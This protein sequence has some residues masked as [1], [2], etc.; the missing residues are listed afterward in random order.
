MGR[1]FDNT[2]SDYL[3]S[4]TIPIQGGVGSTTPHTF[5]AWIN[6][7]K[8]DIEQ[9][10]CGFYDKLTSNQWST[11]LFNS[12]GTFRAHRRVGGGS[13]TADT[14]ATVTANTWHHTCAV[15]AAPA[16]T[17]AYLDNRSEGQSTTNIADGNNLT[18]I[19]IGQHRDTS[20]SRAFS[21]AIAELSIHNIALSFFER[22][23]LARWRYSALLV[24]PE[25]LVWYRSFRFADL[26]FDPPDLLP[27]Q[28]RQVKHLLFNEDNS[29]PAFGAHPPGI[30][31]PDVI[32]AAI[33]S[34][35]VS[36]GITDGEL[37][38]AATSFDNRPFKPDTIF[39]P[40]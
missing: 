36:V 12:N 4:D 29:Y 17:R 19:G 24:R 31:Y 7:G 11:M 22:D 39:V 33:L 1:L 35:G 32:D 18:H 14:V 15:M 2:V 27:P 3:V 37:A 28:L 10:I 8:A 26:N 38:A 40:S 6:T 30:V 21:G 23:Q 13:A 9:V 34:A 5:C 25:H 16:E 20:P